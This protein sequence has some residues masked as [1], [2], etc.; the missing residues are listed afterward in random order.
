MNHTVRILVTFIESWSCQKTK[1][2]TFS[3]T[4]LA[5]T[6]FPVPRCT[7]T[8]VASLCVFT[9]LRTGAINLTFINV[10]KSKNNLKNNLRW[11]LEFVVCVCV[12]TEAGGG[13]IWIHFVSRSAG[14]DESGAIQIGTHMLAHFLITV[15]IMSKVYIYRTQNNCFSPI[16]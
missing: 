12:C 2:L 9:E 3:L 11:T 8:V 15:S 14:A 16:L 4:H 7:R 6:Y 5:I 13:A 10:C 1:V